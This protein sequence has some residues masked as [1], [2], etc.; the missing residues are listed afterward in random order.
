M[1]TAHFVAAL[2]V[3]AGTATSVAAPALGQSSVDQAFLDAVREKGV[4]VESDADA[5]ALAHR[6]CEVL[7]NGG[8]AQDALSNITKATSWSTEQ[9]MNFGS[10]AVVAYC[11]D[12]AA[13]AQASIREAQ[14]QAQQ[15]QESPTSGGG[16]RTNVTKIPPQPD[17]LPMPP[18][19]HYP[20]G[21]PRQR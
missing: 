8:S 21:P 6:T 7:G 2:V 12:K 3:A 4:P 19:K 20:Y 14:Q 11:K 13:A 9:A 15:A 5:V 1:R 10:L 17:P 16:P 18:P